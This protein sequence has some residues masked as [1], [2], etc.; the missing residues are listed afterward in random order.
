VLS[1]LELDMVRVNRRR[2]D[3]HQQNQR[4]NRH[5]KTGAAT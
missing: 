1:E 3:V 4:E 5:F 2:Y